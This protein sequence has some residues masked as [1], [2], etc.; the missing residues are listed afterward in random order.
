MN[1]ATLAQ[2]RAARPDASSWVAANAG[3]GKTKVLTDRVA[4]L[5]LAGTAPQR[6]LCLTYT[7][8]AAAEMQNRLF[9]TLGAWAMLDDDPLRA[10]L[11]ELGT[12]EEHLASD[13]LDAARRL[14]AKALETPGGL[15]IQTIHA[16]CEVIL[17][18]FP[19]EAGIAPQF[20]VLEDRQARAMRAEVLD[21][22]A[23]TLPGAVADLVRF[24]S[25]DDP[26]GLLSEIGRHRAAFAQ[27]FDAD[28]LARAFGADPELDLAELAT[29]TVTAEDLECLR[30]FLPILSAS[31]PNDARAGA[32]FADALA[33]DPRERLVL[34]ESVLLTGEGAAEP[35]SAKI[36][37]LPTKAVRAAH[38][39]LSGALDDLMLRV[40]AARAQRVAQ[41]AFEK[42]SALNRF[43]RTWIAA[44]DGRKA[45]GG[46]LDFDD[47][48]D[49][50]RL[51]LSDP[52]VAAWVLWRLD[53]G[54]DH[55]LV[56][57]AQDTSPAQW[58]VVR[59]VSEEFFSGESAR[60]GE[61]TIF[62]VGDEKQSIYS[63]Q[64]ADPDAFG[65]MRDRYRTALEEIGRTLESC[66]LIHSFR[67][68]PP[69]LDLVNAVFA[70]PAGMGL[71]VSEAHTAFFSDLPGRVE[72]WPF[73][74]KDEKAQEEPWYLPVDSRP[75]N[76][77]VEVLARKLAAEL[78][79][80]LN[81]G[82][83][84]PDPVDPRP[85]RAGDVMILVQ[86]R[87]P[88]FE[89]IIRALKKAGVP[90]AGADVLRVGG[91]LAVRDLLAACRIAATPG[92]DLSLAALLRSPLGEASETALFSLAHG[93]S[94]TLHAAL[95]GR[96]D[97]GWQAAREMV[98]DLI[99]TADFL[100]PYE[101]LQRLLIR[102]DGRRRL[103][104]RLGPEAEDGID[105]LLDLALAYERTEAPS[106]TG[107]L[108]WIDR[109]EIRVKRRLEETADQV[110]VMTVH[111]AKGLEANI[112]ILPD[113][114]ARQEG[115]NAPEILT[116]DGG[117]P[118]WRMPAGAAPEAIRDA[119]QARRDR[120]RAEN[121]RLLYVALTRA[122]RWL[123][124]C[125]AGAEPK[126]ESGAW[127]PLVR[128]A[129]EGLSPEAVVGPDGETRLVLTHAWSD[130][131]DR[132]AA[133][134][135][136]REPEAPPPWAEMRAPARPRRARPLSPSL[137]GGAHVVEAVPGE[138]Q[139]A[140]PE[141]LAR[142]DA[143]HRLIETLAGQDRGR[144]AD[145]A[146]RVVPE[147]R[148]DFDALLAE[149]EA[150]LTAPALA[151]LFGPGSLAEVDVT[152]D[153]PEPVARRMVGRI[154]RLLVEP[155]RILAV[156]FKSNRAVPASPEAIPEGILRQLG[157]YRAALSR[158]WSDR[159]VTTAIV[160]TR[161]ATLM[162]V[163]DTLV[164][165]AIARAAP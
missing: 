17:R 22:L 142:G 133:A 97:P 73:L 160:W 15:K 151:P 165:A 30:A 120:A 78:A 47:M 18:R 33:A 93:R 25:G 96:T 32:A 80:L 114:G 157:A 43:A 150:V 38:D 98:E 159:P 81:S 55:V 95:R 27:P 19:L 158:I 16:F 108:A 110:R 117:L 154:D 136:S 75:P 57:E 10:A 3:S 164:D 101:M 85:V 116:L 124:V 135:A 155:G 149:A 86:R 7:K 24:L 146:R 9:A 144:W 68:A 107:F 70:G 50:T 99:G 39:G 140:D 71:D 53:G 1:E 41:A 46:L 102:H 134:S 59:A 121:M 20:Q 152:A 64:G 115:R 130:A 28:A 113:T 61:R 87:G 89:A 122:C 79:G 88:L 29:R 4:R 2:I 153:L 119:E 45:A 82:A 69:V 90:V 112:V 83:I 74:P 66:S 106:L 49:R 94:G 26:D 92:D 109:D 129:I 91:E 111:G 63:F 127:Y 141:A 13:N 77:P 143:I 65:E 163:P 23:E 118:V 123:I 54:I 31:G 42:S 100:R 132:D 105:A 58:Q 148:T 126:P 60:P 52:G 131:R 103:V 5:L 162:E 21:N 35:F 12:D 51:L 104:A 11:R 139:P 34:L 128:T 76:D 138:E 84:L 40:E 156:D 125:G 36:G 48:I 6:I 72:V 67:S 56:D 147:T 37:K 14:F 8:A 44:L 161:E 62:V 145:L 137:L